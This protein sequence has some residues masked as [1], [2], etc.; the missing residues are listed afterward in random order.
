M[1]AEIPEDNVSTALE[2]RE[3]E[4]VAFARGEKPIYSEQI[5]GPAPTN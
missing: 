5:A 1:S 2:D 3:Y 4:I